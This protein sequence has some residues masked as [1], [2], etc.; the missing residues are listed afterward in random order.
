MEQTPAMRIRKLHA[1]SFGCLRDL[2]VDL[3]PLTVFVGP[4]DSGKS[5]LLRALATL[6]A[7]SRLPLG[8]RDVFPSPQSLLAQTFDGRSD[9]VRLGLA[10]DLGA[11]GF[12]YD[13]EVSAAL[14]YSAIKSEHVRLSDVRV[15]R[16][17]T[18]FTFLAQGGKEKTKDVP[19]G[20]HPLLHRDY[21]LAG[22]LRADQEVADTLRAL[23]PLLS[24][25]RTMSSYSLRPESLR[26]PTGPGTSLFSDGSG[27]S[28]ALANL[29]LND[30]DAAERLEKA[31]CEVMP[32]VRRLGLSQ[33][34]GAAGGLQYDFELVTRSGARVPG[35]NISDGVLL[36]IGYLYLALGP[37]PAS[38]LLVEEP[39]TGIH[40][41]LLK[42]VTKL[43]RDLSTGA[44]GGPPTQVILTTHSP[45]LLNLVEPEEIRIV[46]RGDDGATKVSRF[47]DAPG[48]A[49]LLDYQGPGEIWVNQGEE[50]LT[51][52]SA[53]HS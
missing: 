37:N 35:V 2:T 30:R 17:D 41:G 16:A 32:Q 11:S 21:L 25:V 40:F 27:L 29:L 50:Y 6:A 36:Y 19:D 39:E 10:G 38:V 5:T 22:A 42:S 9:A 26:L 13:V 15:D 7:A 28:A 47:S 18:K 31:L 20:V 8:W 46:E 23:S 51:R 4:N 53:S 24:A 43:F 3:E 52:R 48:L 44:H 12:E 33:Q 34:A 45:M 14:G 49:K 1:G